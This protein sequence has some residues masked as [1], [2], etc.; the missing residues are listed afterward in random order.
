MRRWFALAGCALA[1][2]VVGGVAPLDAAETLPELHPQQV[3]L[4][5]AVP[6]EQGKLLSVAVTIINTGDGDA[7][8]FS[9][10][11]AW[12]RLG[13]QPGA[14]TTFASEQLAG[15]RVL[16]QELT[17]NVSLDTGTLGSGQAGSLDQ[18]TTFELRV[19]LDAQNAVAEQDESNNELRT[20]F[21]VFPTLTLGKADLRPLALTFDPVSPVSVT[22]TRQDGSSGNSISIG[23]VVQNVGDGNATPFAVQISYCAVPLSRSGRSCPQALQPLAT[24]LESNPD[25]R[26]LGGLEQGG[27]L[28][29]KAD[30]VFREGDVLLLPAGTYL[31]QIEVDPVTVENPLGQVQE[32]DEANNVLV[33]FLTV[34]GPEL[35]PTRIDLGTTPVRQGE[36]VNVIATIAN[37]GSSRAPSGYRVDFLINGIPFASQDGPAIDPGGRGTVRAQLNT[38]EF[39]L[40]AGKAQTIGVVVDADNRVFEPDETNNAL[41]T[42]LTLIP[43]PPSLAEL[44]PKNIVL[45]PPSPI[46]KGRDERLVVNASLVNTGNAPALGFEIQFAYRSQGARRWQLIPCTIPPAGCRNQSLGRGQELRA[47]GEIP[48]E[49]LQAGVT[50]ELRVVVDPVTSAGGAGLIAELD[51]SNNALQ[52]TFTVRVPLLPDLLIESLAFLPADLS[53]VRPGQIVQIKVQVSNLG[54]VGVEQPVEV[55]CT[56]TN[57]VTSGVQPCP[58]STPGRI[59]LNQGLAV[60]ASVAVAFQL[61]TT[62][63]LPGFYQ[64]ALEVD[65][66]NQVRESDEGNNTLVTSDNL[67]ENV[68]TVQGAD[69]TVIPLFD[70]PLPASVIQGEALSVSVV[71]L[72]QG[73]EN[74]PRFVVRLSVDCPAQATKVVDKEFL[75]LG[76]A[77]SAAVTFVFGDA[78]DPQDPTSKLPVGQCNLNVVVDPNG[79]VTETNE[80]NNALFGDGFGAQLVVEPTL[81]DLVPLELN[82]NS[83]VRASALS[84][85]LTATV[86]NQGGRPSGP[87]LAQ[88]AL[89]LNRTAATFVSRCDSEADFLSNDR[90]QSRRIDGVAPGESRQIN[91]DFALLPPGSYVVRLAVDASGRVG[92]EVRE[93]DETN[94]VLTLAPP[95]EILPPPPNLRPLKLDYPVVP[96]RVGQP[97]PIV[98]EVANSGG[99]IAGAFDVQFSLCK[100][101]PAANVFCGQPDDFTPFPDVQGAQGQALNLGTVAVNSVQ[102]NTTVR[103]STTLITSSLGVGSYVLRVVVDAG[104]ALSESDEFD[105]VL[106]TQPP[107]VLQG[108]EGNVANGSAPGPSTGQTES[109]LVVANFDLGKTLLIKGTTLSFQFDVFNQ[110]VQ[111]AGDFS[112]RVFY[113]V[114]GQAAVEFERFRVLGLDPKVGITHK[115]A[116]DT[117]GFDAGRYRI[118]VIVD[119]FNEVQESF[120]ANNRQERWFQLVG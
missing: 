91:F 47:Q 118:I 103:V 63:L 42:A 96:V 52:T 113:Q 72:N 116:F 51:E 17:R 110:G 33:G 74:A 15:L 49:Q 20:S 35:R 111:A 99:E 4:S 12:R 48:V 41:E 85:T 109:D 76:A 46:E 38:G 88:V 82:F 79:A 30:L 37:D 53:R 93:S 117:A 50:Y 22:S 62:T 112:V 92:G 23:S 75:G 97:V 101:D 25:G 107:L 2:V 71:V 27:T 94:N 104:N 18:T 64:V 105:N 16:D 19:R 45:T 39:Q 83:P 54:E 120:E 69:L 34:R 119:A 5:P 58:G 13:V 14:W 40:A 66:Q 102:P 55:V 68:L 77:D 43:A 115:S 44:H 29:F 3:V 57:L 100:F 84:F 6:L 106:T 7:K 108:V 10:D 21:T 98:A 59:T 95:L 24:R 8:G 11:Y 9:I 78:N 28:S 26:A 60:G 36:V 56:L 73:L 70:A 86:A 65:P 67:D 80:L 87:F 114:V 89:C 61:D 81:A 31:F 32:Q 90:T 1:L